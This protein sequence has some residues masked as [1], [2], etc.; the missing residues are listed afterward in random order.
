MK[1][2][3]FILAGTV[4]LFLSSLIYREKVTPINVNFPIDR[5][6]QEQ[7][8]S[9]EI[10]PS[11]KTELNLILFF[12]IKNCPPCL[13]VIDILNNPPDGVRVIGIV[14]E[15]ELPLLDEIRQTTSAKFPIYSSKKLRKYY[16]VY[17]PTLYGIGPDGVI[18]F[19]LPCVGTEEIYL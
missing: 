16:P 1:K 9:A 10:K 5:L 13:R 7:K 19:I 4:I 12:S 3:I 8:T 15:K 2:L 14:P 6:E 11:G 17:A 18:Y